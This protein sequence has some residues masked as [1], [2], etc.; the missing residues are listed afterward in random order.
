VGT[1]ASEHLARMYGA[2]ADPVT[3]TRYIAMEYLEGRDLQKV[4]RQ[5]P[6]RPDVAL[7]IAA[8]ACAGLVAAHRAGF[9]HRDIKPANVF[10]AVESQGAVTVKL[11]DFGI[12]KVSA[13]HAIDPERML[14]KTGNLLG[15][16][17][18][19]A[20]EQIFGSKN[21]DHRADLWS[22]G[23]TLY[24]ALTGR[25]PH[26]EASSIFALVREICA[27]PPEDVREA[28]PWIPGNIAA[29]VARALQLD[30]A[31]RF[32]SA[33]AML[34]AMDRSLSS[35][36]VLSVSMLEPLMGPD[37]DAARQRSARSGDA[38]PESA[39]STTG[40]SWEARMARSAERP[41]TDESPM[42][43]VVGRGA[44][45]RLSWRGAARI[46]GIAALVTVGSGVLALQ[47]RR[48]PTPLDVATAAE[49]PRATPTGM[50]A[51][52]T[53]LIHSVS[54]SI[55]PID[56]TVELDGASVAAAHGAFTIAG[57]L[58]S[59]H[60]VRLVKGG[61]ARTEDVVITEVGALPPK[62]AI[63]SG[64]SSAS[65]SSARRRAAPAPS[66]RTK[67]R[68]SFE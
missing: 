10:L 42:A 28:A 23:I 7:K 5:G 34:A 14:T 57:K 44:G 1:I 55:E 21:V 26:A 51:P 3:G 30:P 36:R 24:H 38:P 53:A 13:Q 35:D 9:V 32:E 67:L 66:A 68:T 16:P 62:L 18:Y 50:P 46:G 40:P 2:G 12:A 33:E 15:T 17:H 37:V 47:V 4:L 61:E 25:V 65:P 52:D 27:A 56:A 64:P 31:A 49:P 43:A 48:P 45:A 63:V 11:L 19:F 41:N 8:Q 54:L 60:R 39:S 59:V 29:V 58:G 6:L 22:L 20:P